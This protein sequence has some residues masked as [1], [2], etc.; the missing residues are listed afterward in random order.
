MSFSRASFIENKKD[1]KF[2]RV[3]QYS[4]LLKIIL[5]FNINFLNLGL[6]LFYIFNINY[7]IHNEKKN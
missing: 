1:R 7:N 5:F 6:A 3:E 2:L 4:T